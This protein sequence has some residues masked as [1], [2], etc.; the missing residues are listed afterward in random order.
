MLTSN[1]SEL[2]QQEDTLM[3]EPIDVARMFSLV[4][5]KRWWVLASVVF[6]SVVAV[7]IAFLTTPTYRASVVLA[8]TVTERGGDLLGLGAGQLSG[9]A[10]LAGLNLGPKESETEEAVAVLQSREF[11]DKF[12][13]GKNLMPKLFA[14]K[15]DAEKGQWK[16]DSDHQ[17]TPAKAYK[18][19]NKRIRSITRD[20]KAGLVT[21]QIDWRDRK[22]AAVWANDLVRQLNEEMRQRAIAKADAAMQFLE[23]ELQ[24]TAT[25]EGRSAISRLMEVQLKQRMLANVT[26]DYSFRVIDPALPADKDDPIWPLKAALLV[27]GPFFGLFAGIFLVSYFG[28]GRQS[29]RSLRKVE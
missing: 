26:P 19:F 21:L 15:W 9:L 7:A 27:G 28:S 12:I 17:P 20:K 3:D 13:T 1:R 24:K 23:T 14:S 2:L 6:F 16:V 4:V 5:A 18:Y 25:V 29:G 10:S 8:P 11:T 22:E